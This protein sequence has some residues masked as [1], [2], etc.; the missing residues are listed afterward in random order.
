MHN[1]FYVDNARASVYREILFLRQKTRL[2]LGE[3]APKT[4]RPLKQRHFQDPLRQQI[5]LQ[6]H[7]H[8]SALASAGIQKDETFADLFTF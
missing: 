1:V 5:Y 8:L 7:L 4:I 6:I 2:S 3:C